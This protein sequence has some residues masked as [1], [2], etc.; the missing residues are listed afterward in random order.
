MPTFETLGYI[1]EYYV[2]RKFIGFI[3][4]EESDRGK[5]YGYD[6]R[7]DEV[8][9]ELILTSNKR[10]I[11]PGTTAMTIVYPMNGKWNRD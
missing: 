1:K 6:N 2:N 7:K 5:A 8:I 11:K 3:K 9:N 4:L 10:K